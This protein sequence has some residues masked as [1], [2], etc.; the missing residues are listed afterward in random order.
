MLAKAYNEA[1]FAL[2]DN[3]EYMHT[4]EYIYKEL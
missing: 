3:A 2:T 1:K 4:S